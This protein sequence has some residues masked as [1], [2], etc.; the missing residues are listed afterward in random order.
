MVQYIQKGIFRTEAEEAE[1]VRWEGVEEELGEL[2]AVDNS[3]RVC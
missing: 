2:G 3:G 1:L